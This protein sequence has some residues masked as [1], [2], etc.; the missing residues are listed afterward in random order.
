MILPAR[1][2]NLP[3]KYP[4]FNGVLRL[5]ITCIPRPVKRV[6]ETERLC[7]KYGIRLVPA[8]GD[9]SDFGY[10]HDCHGYIHLSRKEGMPNTVLEA[11][12]YG[13]P[14]I[15]TNHG[16]AKEAIGDAGIIINNDPEFP[17]WKGEIEPIDDFLFE[18]AIKKFIKRLPDLRLRAR[19]RVL[20]QLNDKITAERFKKLY[21]NLCL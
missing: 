15:I 20:T 2:A 10:Y 8:Y 5:A 4:D 1:E 12:A 7:E 18:E 3:D 6:E 9:V 21:E 14:C 19:G 17:K 13:L 16:G 11:L